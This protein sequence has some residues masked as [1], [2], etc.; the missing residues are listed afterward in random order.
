LDAASFDA[1]PLVVAPSGAY[2][3]PENRDTLLIG[4]AHEARPEPE[5]SYEDQDHVQPAFFH[6]GDT[7]SMA[8]SAWAAIAEVIPAVGEFAGLT[9][10]TCGYYATTPDHNPFLDID[11]AVPNLVRL[12][13]F[14]GHGAMFG[15]F[16]ALVA[17][18]LAEGGRLDAVDTDAG[19][20]PLAPFAIGRA[21]RHEE[22]LVL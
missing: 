19:R 18:A 8:F 21:Y 6:R 9:A 20:V 22:S 4:W 2:C 15:P 12:A 11:P 5:F 13:G 1:M 17:A 7:D 10:T 16:T 14:S 3:R